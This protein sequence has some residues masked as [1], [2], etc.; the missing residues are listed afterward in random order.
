[1]AYHFV[2]ETDAA[3]QLLVVSV[4]LVPENGPVG[5]VQGF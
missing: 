1:M 2:E 5:I 4:F 3:I